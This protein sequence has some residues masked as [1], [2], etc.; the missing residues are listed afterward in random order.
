MTMP[1]SWKTN[2]TDA[3]VVTENKRKHDRV[4]VTHDRTDVTVVFEIEE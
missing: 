4:G 3:Q 2:K 1:V